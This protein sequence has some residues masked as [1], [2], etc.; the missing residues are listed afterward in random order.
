VPVDVT[1][2]SALDTL[3]RSLLHDSV[4]RS[5]L[6]PSLVTPRDTFVLEGKFAKAMSEEK[7][8]C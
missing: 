4:K 6:S 8:T 2:T 3:A 7:R 1:A 5:A